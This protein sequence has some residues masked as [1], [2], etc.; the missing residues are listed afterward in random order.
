VNTDPNTYYDREGEPIAIE[1]YARL[2]ADYA[3]KVVAKEDLGSS[4]EVSTVWLG[5][6]HNFFG[7]GPPLIFETMIFGGRYDEEQW[8]WSTLDEARAGHARIV[9]ALKARRDPM[10]AANAKEIR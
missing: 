10:L 5:I 9:A 3:Y 1:D 4:G 2:H 7:A 6:D 8:R